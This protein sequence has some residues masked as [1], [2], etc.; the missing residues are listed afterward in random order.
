LRTI[1][2]YRDFLQLK[3]KIMVF[4]IGDHYFMK[5]CQKLKKVSPTLYVDYMEH[6]EDKCLFGFGL[7]WPHQCIDIQKIAVGF[8]RPCPANILV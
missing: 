3:R 2:K 4:D 7:G 1:E 5:Q 6:T 8:S